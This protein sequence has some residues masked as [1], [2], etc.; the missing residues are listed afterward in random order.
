MIELR[1]NAFFYSFKP[2]LSVSLTLKSNVFNLTGGGEYQKLHNQFFKN[3]G[4]AHHVSCPHT[5][6][7]NGSAERKHRHIVETGLALLAH[8]SV[9]IKFWDEAFLTA[10]Y[11]I[12]R[13]PTRVLDNLC[14][15]ERLFKTPPN[16]SM[17]RIFGCACWPH[18]RPYNQHKLSFRSKA[19]VFLG[20]SGLH[21]GYKCLDMDSGRIYISRDVIFD[22]T[23]FPFSNIPSSNVAPNM[24]SSSINLNTNH[25]HIFPG[26]F[27]HAAE[28]PGAILMEAPTTAVPDPAQAASQ[29]GTGASGSPPGTPRQ[30]PLPQSSPAD[31]HQAGQRSPRSPPVSPA[32]Q[33]PDAS[34]DQAVPASADQAGPAPNVA[35]QPVA[36]LE[37]APHN[38]PAHPHRTRL[39]H[40]L[41]Q[42]KIRTDGTVTYSAVRT[43]D[44]VP[45]SH[46]TALANP[47]WQS[48][49]NK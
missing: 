36:Q 24:D 26:N 7:Q 42:P 40:N 32:A 28:N 30:Q 19:C 3:L 29:P 21:K 46:V 20:Y 33:P 2:M 38:P 47:L 22:E 27:M 6:Q 41:R 31:A 45:T 8:A 18:L 14:P 23:K 37:A 49:M 11:L 10:T 13:L 48:A 34:A 4:I 16:Y 39:S 17:L 35:P 44:A 43:T 15:L 12:N 5:H 1:L 25:I 9:P